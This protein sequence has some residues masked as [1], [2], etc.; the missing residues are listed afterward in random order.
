MTIATENVRTGEYT[1]FDNNNVS[2]GEEICNAALCSSS[3]PV[4]F[5]PHFFKGEYY[6]D[7]GTTWNLNISSAVNG[8]KALGF[9]EERITVDVLICGSADLIT[10]G[11]EGKTLHNFQRG[12][13]I[14][15]Y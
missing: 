6:M 10:P 2:F 3:I 12:R 8:C 15:K 14:K 11:E 13:K 7:G 1:T 4:V 9:D 5:P